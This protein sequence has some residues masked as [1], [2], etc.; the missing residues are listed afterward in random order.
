MFKLDSKQFSILLNHKD[1]PER[2]REMSGAIITLS[3]E[4]ISH[5]DVAAAFE[6]EMALHAAKSSMEDYE[7]RCSGYTVAGSMVR[8]IEDGKALAKDAGLVVAFQVVRNGDGEYK[9]RPKFKENQQNPPGTVKYDYYLNG[10]K[11]EAAS[12]REREEEVVKRWPKSHAADTIRK[13]RE[14]RASGKKSSMGFRA[15]IEGGNKKGDNLPIA[16]KERAKAE[17]PKT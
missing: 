14:A 17:T 9:L 7:K 3:A 11:W 1:N 13:Y 4:D 8:L 2:F 5:D 15:I 12:A 6:R 16:W 10:E